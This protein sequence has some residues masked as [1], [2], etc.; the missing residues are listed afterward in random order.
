M[1]HIYIHTFNFLWWIINK[2]IWPYFPIIKR[3]IYIDLLAYLQYNFTI[4]LSCFVFAI[5]ILQN[6][7]VWQRREQTKWIIL[8]NC[9]EASVL[10]FSHCYFHTHGGGGQSYGQQRHKSSFRKQN[11]AIWE[12]SHSYDGWQSETQTRRYGEASQKVSKRNGWQSGI[13]AR[14]CL[15]AA[16]AVMI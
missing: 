12:Q 3:E 7:V 14:D 16:I 5:W 11:R 8:P 9:S 2:F 10:L 15:T 6:L 4:I 13:I 1:S